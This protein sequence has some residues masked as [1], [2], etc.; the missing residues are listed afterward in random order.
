MPEHQEPLRSR[1]QAEAGGGQ[2]LHMLRSALAAPTTEL[3][4]K[5]NKIA[6]AL[7]CFTS[8]DTVCRSYRRVGQN[9]ILLRESFSRVL[10]S[11]AEPPGP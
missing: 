4:N 8:L 7:G 3:G 6:E 9:Y 5:N 11:C 10:S 1:S 2:Y